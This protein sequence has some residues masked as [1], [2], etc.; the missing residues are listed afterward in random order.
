MCGNMIYK[1]NPKISE[2]N[3]WCF[4][5]LI[6]CGF[7]E[8]IAPELLSYFFY[9]KK[10]SEKCKRWCFWKVVLS[11]SKLRATVLLAGLLSHCLNLPSQLLSQ[12]LLPPALTIPRGGQRAIIKSILC[13]VCKKVVLFDAYNK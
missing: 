3:P 9:S 5:I 6:C 1:V 8:I 13:V 7:P 11:L 12:F 10:V 4:Y 2:R